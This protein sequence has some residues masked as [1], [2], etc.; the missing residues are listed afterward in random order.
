[1]RQ[2]NIITWTYKKKNPVKIIMRFF[3]IKRP[4]NRDKDD[5]NLPS[6][7]PSLLISIFKFYYRYSK[8][9]F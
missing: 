8:H 6:H 4:S 7:D 5:K 9:D 2:N 3:F 1:M